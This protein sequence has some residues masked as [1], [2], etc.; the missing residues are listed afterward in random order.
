MHKTEV[1][2]HYLE[3]KLQEVKKAGH[4]KGVQ[5]IYDLIED[6]IKETN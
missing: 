2:R 4:G 6:A 3:S 5:E 1:A